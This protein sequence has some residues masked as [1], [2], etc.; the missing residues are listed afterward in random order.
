MPHAQKQLPSPS[1]KDD[2]V[3]AEKKEKHIKR[4]SK[5]LSD[6]EVPIATEAPVPAAPATDSS[7][8]P[9]PGAKPNPRKN[10]NRNSYVGT[11]D[12][13]FSD[14]S[15]KKTCSY[16]GSFTVAHL[17]PPSRAE[18]VRLQLQ[19]LQTPKRSREVS[20]FISMSG[21]K[22][23]SPEDDGVVL[24]AHA[25]KRI[26]YATCDP[27]FKQFAFLARNPKGPVGI[28]YCHVF[29]TSEKYEVEEIN[30]I[31]SKAFKVAYASIRS[32]RQFV[33]LVN[34]LNKEQEEY[35]TQVQKYIEAKED[36]RVN[37]E[38]LSEKLPLISPDRVRGVGVGQSRVWAKQIAGRVSHK[39]PY[40]HQTEEGENNHFT[41]SSNEVFSDE[42]GTS[43]ESGSKPS[44]PPLSIGESQGQQ[45]VLTKQTQKSKQ[46]PPAPYYEA[47]LS[48]NWETMGVIPPSGI[49]VVPEAE[50]DQ[51]CHILLQN[52]LLP[53]ALAAQSGPTTQVNGRATGQI[54]LQDSSVPPPFNY[55]P[56]EDGRDEGRSRRSSRE[57]LDG[58]GYPLEDDMED[59]VCLLTQGEEDDEDFRYQ[60]KCAEQ[61][62]NAIGD[63]ESTDDEL[64]Y[65][66]RREM[67]SEDEDNEEE[68][69]RLTTP[70]E[71]LTESEK[72]EKL[73]KANYAIPGPPTRAI[74]ACDPYPSGGA[75]RA[76]G[77]PERP[78]E[79]KAIPELEDGAP[80]QRLGY[81]P[82]K[83]TSRLKNTRNSVIK[84]SEP[85]EKERSKRH[86]N[87]TETEQ[88]DSNEATPI[89]PKQLQVD[90]HRRELSKSAEELSTRSKVN[91]DAG[92]CQS[93]GTASRL[94]SPMSDNK[95]NYPHSY[96]S[97]N[98]RRKRAPGHVNHKVEIEIG[99]FKVKKTATSQRGSVP[100]LPPRL[101]D[102]PTDSEKQTVTGHDTD[103]DDSA[104]SSSLHQKEPRKP[105]Q[106]SRRSAESFTRAPWFKA[107]I[108][109][110]IAFEI[111]RQQ[112]KGAFIVRESKSHTGCYA[113]SIKVDTN[114]NDS[115][116]A[117][118]LVVRTKNGGYTIKGFGRDFPDLPRL[119]HY[120]SLHKEQ[121]PCKLVFS[122][123]NPLYKQGSKQGEESDGEED[124]DYKK[125]TD[126]SSMLL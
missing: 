126:F 29:I 4:R 43:Q 78:S 69:Q 111:L 50:G 64:E 73:I 65:P 55:N 46:L 39:Q 68:E 24:M 124:P 58:D 12:D 67:W 35:Q 91:G 63:I 97:N 94:L 125:L 33:R 38:E 100:P 48:N 37:P 80:Y 60:M 13:E 95:E 122:G 28:Q 54:L 49:S 31:V 121:L 75:Q 57:E 14:K 116:I 53:P 98:E 66:Y 20:L 118:Y 120:Y 22:V 107:G 1:E 56:R 74:F 44:A 45:E 82:P 41:Y 42:E 52:E 21:I 9:S 103:A 106:N 85:Q 51:A 70:T 119:V 16:V 92:K 83:P 81:S 113:I 2:Q 23:C 17:S 114:F 86:K 72:R 79:S 34:E 101:T 59:T 102:I 5:I 96:H 90:C 99:Q 40:I 11:D 110:D 36:Q 108:P 123:T 105:E 8:S 76:D 26:S 61:F 10:Q 32:K 30:A 47:Q 84:D 77:H 62:I 109:K 27:D 15:V 25:L 93:E 19:T 18:F 117:N 88:N 87:S 6:D 71:P 104:K 7:P 112:E 115:R 3:L 89:R